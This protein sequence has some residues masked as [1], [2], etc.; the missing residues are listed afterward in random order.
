LIEIEGRLPFRN[1]VEVI[2]QSELGQYKLAIL[3]LFRLVVVLVVVV[4][5]LETGIIKLSQPAGAGTGAELGK[6]V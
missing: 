2:F 3:I 1:L 4:V 5:A 6:N